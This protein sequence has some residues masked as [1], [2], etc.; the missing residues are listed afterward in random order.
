[1][2]KTAPFKKNMRTELLA[3]SNQF[4]K[5]KGFKINSSNE[6][7]LAAGQVQDLSKLLCNSFSSLFE[8]EFS[9]KNFFKNYL[10]LKRDFFLKTS[11]YSFG[12]SETDVLLY[13]NE[14]EIFKSDLLSPEQLLAFLTS[15]ED[16]LTDDQKLLAELFISN[17]TN[18]SLLNYSICYLNF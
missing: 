12:F 6:F 4:K 14:K 13:K 1:M 7:I 18:F 17:E 10:E 9:N 5:I 15:S 11:P 3:L 2:K 16:E 8:E